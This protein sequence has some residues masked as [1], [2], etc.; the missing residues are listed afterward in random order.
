MVFLLHTPLFLFLMLFLFL[1]LSSLLLELSYPLF[2]LLDGQ[3][4]IQ[5]IV[6]V[7][8]A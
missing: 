7:V 4:H 8:A 3:P 6:A 5:D 1:H 2:H